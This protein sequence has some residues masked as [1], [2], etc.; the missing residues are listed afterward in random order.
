MNGN[1]TFNR[2]KEIDPRVRVI[3]SSGYS[4]DGQAQAIL[5]NGCQGFLQKPFDIIELAKEIR[6]VLKI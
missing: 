1:E 2:L 4:R 5:E 6:N 3:L